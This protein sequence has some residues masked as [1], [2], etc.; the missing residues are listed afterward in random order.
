MVPLRA[1][2]GQ[3]RAGL[4]V[5]VG[6]PGPPGVREVPVSLGV[7]GPVGPRSE[8]VGNGPATRLHLP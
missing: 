1:E 4:R 8:V 7:L 2:G 3:I 6:G 5:L